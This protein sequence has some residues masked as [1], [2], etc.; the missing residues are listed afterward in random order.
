M[1]LSTSQSV[2][3]HDSDSW[4]LWDSHWCQVGVRG[5]LQV[6]MFC[7]FAFA[8]LLS[9]PGKVRGKVHGKGVDGVRDNIV[10][11]LP[12]KNMFTPMSDLRQRR[13]QVASRSFP[14]VQDYATVT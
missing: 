10:L 8:L 11:C 12:E 1:R 9:A 13:V 2:V 7:G 4:Y 6:H 3:G 14:Q 5:V